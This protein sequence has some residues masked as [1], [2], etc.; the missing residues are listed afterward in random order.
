MTQ[1]IRSLREYN[2]ISLVL[3]VTKTT[4]ECKTSEFEL[5]HLALLGFFSSKPKQV[6][7]PRP[8]MAVKKMFCLL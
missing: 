3:H 1:D 8:D 2:S 5:D 6:I 7:N 4:P